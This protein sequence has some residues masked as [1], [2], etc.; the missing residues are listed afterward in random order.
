MIKKKISISRLKLIERYGVSVY[1]LNL[2]PE[3]LAVS[4]FSWICKITT[5][6]KSLLN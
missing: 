5:N 6:E 1:D 4:R 2:L 3:E